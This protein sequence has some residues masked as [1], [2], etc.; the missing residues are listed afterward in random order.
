MQYFSESFEDKMKH[1]NRQMRPS[2]RSSFPYPLRIILLLALGYFGYEMT[3]NQGHNLPVTVLGIGA[4][5][6]SI[7]FI[8]FKRFFR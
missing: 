7:W 2:A 5:L 1:H 8:R 4:L 6:I 3:F